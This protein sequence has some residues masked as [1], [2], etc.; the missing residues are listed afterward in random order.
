MLSI[1]L[2]KPSN[3][4]LL[5]HRFRLLHEWSPV[6]PSGACRIEGEFLF[7]GHDAEIR[8]TSDGDVSAHI[9][10]Q[11]DAG[12]VYAEALDK[13]V[14][15]FLDDYRDHA[16]WT[17]QRHGL[18]GS[19][20]SVSIVGRWHAPPGHAESSR[21]S[22]TPQ[23][24]MSFY[25]MLVVTYPDYGEPIVECFRHAVTCHDQGAPARFSRNAAITRE[26]L[27]KIADGVA[28]CYADT[29][30]YPWRVG[31]RP[32]DGTV[33]HLVGKDGRV[34]D[35][36]IAPLADLPNADQPMPWQ[37]SLVWTSYDISTK[38]RSDWRALAATSA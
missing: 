15:E 28:R 10:P 33:W 20:W 21:G 19:E 34:H 25:P 1:P 24:W 16:A 6:S 22:W 12:P 37:E 29:L 14:A 32:I 35:S 7:T 9:W 31:R 8:V 36:F 11:S 18:A 17:A 23:E 27:R 5:P 2:A 4:I 26:Q 13:R 3:Q 38:F 30:G